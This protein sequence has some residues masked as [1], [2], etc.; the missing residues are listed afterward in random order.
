MFLISLLVPIGL[1]TTDEGIATRVVLQE[2]K[3]I[4][5]RQTKPK[6][7]NFIEFV[8]ITVPLFIEIAFL[9]NFF[10]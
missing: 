4:K 5:T 8:L 9:L 6:I 1:T 3:P 10:T 7:E 2:E